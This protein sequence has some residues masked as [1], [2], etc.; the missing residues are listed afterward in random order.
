M[1]LSCFFFLAAVE[2]GVDDFFFHMILKLQNEYYLSYQPQSLK[3]LPNIDLKLFYHTLS[4]N[5]IKL[6][7]AKTETIL[8]RHLAKKDK[9]QPEIETS[10]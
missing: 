9:L 3:K 8:F 4:A 6:N 5:Q 7:I 2:S 10:R 1:F